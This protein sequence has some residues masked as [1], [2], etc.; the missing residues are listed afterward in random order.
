VV[1]LY[2]YTLNEVKNVHK[3]FRQECETFTPGDV[4]TKLVFSD[5]VDSRIGNDYQE[6]TQKALDGCHSSDGEEH[7]RMQTNCKG[8]ESLVALAACI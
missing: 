5:G 6:A 1:W 2:I 8:E 7:G 4:S 3:K